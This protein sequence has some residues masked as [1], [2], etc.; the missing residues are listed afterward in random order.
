MPSEKQFACV[1]MVKFEAL[2][3]AAYDAM[4]DARRPAT[5]YSDFK[6]FFANAAAAAER[7]GLPQ[8]AKRL[9]ARLEHCRA[10]YRSQFSGS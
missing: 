1:E 2:A 3:E 5:C 6:D 7:A 4:Y 9:R 8:E 10:V